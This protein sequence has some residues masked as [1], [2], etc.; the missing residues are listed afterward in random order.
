M[1]YS[2]QCKGAFVDAG[3]VAP[4]LSRDF[5][6]ELGP[7]GVGGGGGRICNLILFL[8]GTWDLPPGL[9]LGGAKVMG[10]DVT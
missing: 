2:E 4:S 7:P 1:Y 9:C 5:P 6:G 8:R 3:H 10:L